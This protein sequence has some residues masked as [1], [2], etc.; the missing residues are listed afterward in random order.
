MTGI[1]LGP[2]QNASE[3]LIQLSIE[4]ALKQSTT[5]PFDE[6]VALAQ[7]MQ[8]NVTYTSTTYHFL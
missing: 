4:D 3:Q 2:Q 6:F 1:A 8:F 5:M 7:R